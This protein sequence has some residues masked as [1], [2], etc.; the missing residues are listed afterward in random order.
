[1][2]LIAKVLSYLQ[3]ERNG[4]KISDVK[5]GTGGGVNST[6]EEF[7]DSGNDSQPLPDDKVVLIE[8]K[9]TGGKV[10][11][12][13]L[14]PKKQQKAKAGEKRLYARDAEGEEISQVWL[15]NDGTIT[16]NNEKLTFEI[17]PDGALS[18]TNG[19]GSFNLADN[20]VFTVNGVTIDTDGNID[21]PATITANDDVVAD[22]ISLTKHKHIG[23][24]S[25]SAVSGPPE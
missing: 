4:T 5:V 3:T 11:V 18:A 19:N 15:Q 9:R 2:G 6:C 24:T 10:V 12:G 23:V 22:D 20:G 17:T 16:V 1:M 21:S 14:D 8:I 25:G 7:T 13:Y